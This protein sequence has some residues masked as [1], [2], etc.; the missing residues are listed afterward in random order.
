MCVYIYIYI[1]IY[2]HVYLYT[3]MYAYI[4]IYMYVCMYIYIYIYEYL[5]LY[6]YIQGTTNTESLVSIATE[7]VQ[8]FQHVFVAPEPVT[9]IYKR[10][11]TEIISNGGIYLVTYI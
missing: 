7:Q 11:V 9:Q 8:H 6:M 3:Y 5:Y 2:I 1:Y 10:A 4:Y